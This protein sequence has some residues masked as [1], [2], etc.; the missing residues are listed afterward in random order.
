MT[1]CKAVVF[2]GMCSLVSTLI[3]IVLSLV[4]HQCTNAEG[5]IKN[6]DWW[7]APFYQESNMDTFN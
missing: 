7:N 6:R 1:C 4:V 3:I 2:L 5:T